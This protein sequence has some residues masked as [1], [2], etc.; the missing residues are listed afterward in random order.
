M[1]DSVQ[2]VQP[3]R[4]ALL[5]MD[6]QHGILARL[7][8]AGAVIDKAARAIEIVRRAGGHIGFVRVAFTGAEMQAVPDRNKG[9]S[10]IKTM[11]GD[12]GIDSPA[13]QIDERVAPKDGDIVVRKSRVGAFSTTDLAEQLQQRG[14]D[15]LILAGISTSGVVLSTVRDAADRDYRLLVLSDA[16]A[17]PQADVHAL[18]M[19]KVLSR[20]ADVM[21]TA[22]LE[23]L[24]TA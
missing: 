14:V 20:Q 23:K 15:T 3:E 21:V 13:T 8:D 24:F 11:G 2:P 17:D 10:A 7:P 5:V 1:S 18:L 6:Y 22:D 19:E 12:F 9:F 4:T 16:C